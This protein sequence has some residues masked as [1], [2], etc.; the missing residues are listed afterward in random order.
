MQEARFAHTHRVADIGGQGIDGLGRRHAHNTD[1]QRLGRGLH[2]A[3][4]PHRDLNERGAVAANHHL[5]GG[6]A[7][8]EQVHIGA[9]ERV[10]HPSARQSRARRDFEAGNARLRYVGRQCGERKVVAG[11]VAQV[12][13]GRG[14]RDL[15]YRSVLVGSTTAGH[16]V[17]D[18]P[19]DR[20]LIGTAS[21]AARE[22]VQRRE[23]LIIGSTQ[24]K[25]GAAIQIGELA[26]QIPCRVYHQVARRIF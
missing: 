2:H 16:P 3:V 23:S 19:N 12:G 5:A 7:T 15:K 8:I 24:L 25:D 20:Q 4:V 18:S 13:G 17:Q 14:R 22:I 11:H 9:A 10:V 6:L 21:V 26:I 1:A